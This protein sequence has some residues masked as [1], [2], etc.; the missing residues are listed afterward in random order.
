MQAGEAIARLVR[1]EGTGVLATLIRVLGQACPA[2]CRRPTM[3]GHCSGSQRASPDV[4][5]S[6]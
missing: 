4:R 2:S 5:T 3:R 6:S 1:E